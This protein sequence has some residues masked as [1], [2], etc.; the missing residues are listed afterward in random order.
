M[1]KGWMKKRIESAGLAIIIYLDGILVP[2]EVLLDLEEIY[3][4][5]NN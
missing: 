4:I 3:K 2:L 1:L 5:N